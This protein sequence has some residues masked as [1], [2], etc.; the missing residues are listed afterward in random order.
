MVYLLE[1]AQR[2]RIEIAVA[3]EQV[4]LTKKLGR[5]V[6]EQLAANIRRFDFSPQ[7]ETTSLTSGM[8]SRSRSSIPIFRVISDEGQPLQDPR[9]WR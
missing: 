2:I 7:T 1:L 6:G 4:Q 5:L 9:R 3:G 8:A